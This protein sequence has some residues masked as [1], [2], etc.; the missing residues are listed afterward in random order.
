M[1]TALAR[2]A[3]KRRPVNLTIRQDIL[4]EAKGLKL[5]AS[6][7]AEA[8]LIEAVRQEK[9]RRWRQENASAI[10]AHNARV[11]ETGTFLTP[12]WAKS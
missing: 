12:A 2:T 3:Q 8:G 6:K 11:E 10:E 7:V 1:Q 5:N 4:E 9:E